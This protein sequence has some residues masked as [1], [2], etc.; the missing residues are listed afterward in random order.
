MAP[1]ANKPSK[2]QH[3]ARHKELHEYLDELVAD[4]ITITKKLPSQATIMELMEWSSTQTTN[5][6]NPN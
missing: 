5:P 6:I 1:M 2:K 4:W 3:L